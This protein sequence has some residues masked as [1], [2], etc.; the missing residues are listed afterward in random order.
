M[1]GRTKFVTTYNKSFLKPKSNG[2][3]L[4]NLEYS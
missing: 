1:S 4:N 2:N 3:N